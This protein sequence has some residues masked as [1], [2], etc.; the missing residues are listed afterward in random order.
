LPEISQYDVAIVGGGPAGY[1]AALYGSSA[2]LK[3]A[4]I[5]KDKVGG[6]CL[7]RGCVP[8]KEFL[9]FAELY[10]QFFA[11]EKF[12]F[13]TSID[14][15][16]FSVNQERKNKVVDQLFKGLTSLLKKRGVD[17]I[18]GIGRVTT[19][20]TVKITANG[21]QQNIT[22]NSIILATGSYPRQ[23]KGFEFDGKQVISSDDV[24]SLNEL[25]DSI[26]IVG[27]GAIGCEFASFFKDLNKEVILI[28]ML[29]RIIPGLDDEIANFLA[30]SFKKRSI[31]IKTSCVINRI[32]KLEDHIKIEAS[33][34]SFYEI[35]KLLI[36]VG[37]V[38]DVTSALEASLGVELTEKGFIKVNQYYE[39]NIE[40]LYAIGDIIQSPQLAH[41]GFQEG[42]NTIKRILGESFWPIDYSKVPWCI[43]CNPEVAFCGSTENE[44]KE[45]GIG[46]V[47]KKD[48]FGGNSRALIMG[49]GEGMVKVLAKKKSDNQV[50]EILG[51]HM[52]GPLVTELLYPAY[53]ATN[54]QAYPEEIASFLAPHPTLSESLSETVLA[55]TGRSLH[56]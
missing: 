56:V 24:L 39:T 36:A 48:P 16:D 13:K 4:L 34:N 38:P 37:R 26:A 49:H 30:R 2:G 43:Y 45:K 15:F 12:G 18:Q 7:H 51:V 33:D 44:L 21:Q 55:L 20:G 31:E 27:A 8:A 9:H 10:Q 40:N 17:I 5:E 53:L 11:A 14:G 1:A 50:G 23:L 35:E 52:V 42:V 6:T 3:I 29:D 28:E 47:V 32:E 54:W 41:V 22:A 46:Y 25:P 19:P